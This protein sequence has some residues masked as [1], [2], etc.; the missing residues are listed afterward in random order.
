[1]S[2]AAQMLVG[3]CVLLFLSLG[4][5]ERTP[6]LAVGQSLWAIAFL[7]IFGSLVAFS[8]YGYLLRHVRPALATSYAYVNPM[9]AVGLGVLLAGERL[10][11]IELVAIAVTLTGVGLV[12]LG[13]GRV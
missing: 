7:I 13:K 2:S 3:G 5:R 12:S 11:A 9:V 4:L 8:A 10:T 6:N 1:M